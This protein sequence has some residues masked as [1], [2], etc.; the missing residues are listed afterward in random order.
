MFGIKMPWTKRKETREAE[1]RLD[2]E[3]LRLKHLSLVRRRP[4]P[5]ARA[6]SNSPIGTSDDSD[7]FQAIGLVDVFSAQGTYISPV[8]GQGGTFDGGGASGD[9]SS[10]SSSSDSSCSSSD[11]SSSSSDSSSCSSSD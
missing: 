5:T 6:I 1:E 2:R 11:S 9:W 8:S 3:L 7:A 4:A 10:S